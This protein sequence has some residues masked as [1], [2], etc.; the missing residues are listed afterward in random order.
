[1]SYTYSQYVTQ[2]ANLLV[3]PPTDTNYAVVLP[4]I[5]D[6]AEQR[7]YRELDLLNTIIRDTSGVMT[8]GTRNFTFPTQMVVSESL[9]FFTPSGTTQYR[10]QLI[11][12]SREWMDAVYPDDLLGCFDAGLFPRYYA[13][14]T[15]QL[16]IIGPAPDQPYTVEVIGTIRPTPLSVTNTTTY[17]TTYLPDL[18]LAESLIFGY[19]YLQDF[20]AATD[21]PQASASWAQH[22]QDLWQSAAVEEGRKKYSSQAWTPKMP[23]VSATPPRQ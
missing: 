1:M 6:D 22:Y 10:H 4:N 9:N 5:I 17:L 15:D 14:I 21:N 7:I 12:T 3:I 11:P 16:I 13:M 20:G 23:T 18:F 8:V 2:L 19:G